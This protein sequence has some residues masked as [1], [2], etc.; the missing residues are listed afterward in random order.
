MAQLKR[1][2][3]GKLPICNNAVFPGLGS[4]GAWLRTAQLKPLIRNAT[5]VVM[6]LGQ[7]MGHDQLTVCVKAIELN[8]KYI[9]YG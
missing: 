5:I 6:Y 3:A 2:V 7:M 4:Q 1:S 9:V 8:F